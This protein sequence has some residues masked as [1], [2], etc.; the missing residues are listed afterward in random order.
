MQSDQERLINRLTQYSMGAR[1]VFAPDEWKKGNAVREPADI[2]WACNDCVILMYM[3]HAEPSENDERNFKKRNKAIHHNLRQAK[4][5][6]REW[7]SGR[8]LVGQNEYTSYSINYDEYE[9]IIII[10]VI[11]GADPVASYHHEEEKSLS[12]SMCATLPQITIEEFVKSGA[13]A[14]DLITLISG[15]STIDNPVKQEETLEH[16][17]NDQ[18]NIISNVDPD[19]K[20]FKSNIDES[21]IFMQKFLHQL[22]EPNPEPAGK[23]GD[24]TCI[25]QI[26]NDL[27]YQDTLAFLVSLMER[28]EDI[29][30]DWNN[31][32]FQRI[33]LTHYDFII[34]VSDFANSKQATDEALKMANAE[35]NKDR[36]AFIFFWYRYFPGA[37]SAMLAIMG[38]DRPRF[39][40]VFLDHFTSRTH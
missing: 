16:L 20:W 11:A 5:W 18:R 9:H 31:V 35:H 13:T 7:R 36:L 27:L 8:P 26:F 22:K 19:S 39:T 38:D 32:A 15:L 21:F 1:F 4:G 37:E 2:V 33:S 17:Q 10:S 12:V 29:K 24:L 23:S 28:I 30:P 6:L 34:V 3:A 25:A 14:I 40:K